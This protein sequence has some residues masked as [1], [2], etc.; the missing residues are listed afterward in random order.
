MSGV[1]KYGQDIQDRDL[2][3]E[4][5]QEHALNFTKGCYIG[6]EIVERIRSRGAVHRVFSGFI[7]TSGE[8]APG[9]K[10]SA[11]GKDN[12]GII[13]SVQ[14]V[15]TTRDGARTL[16]L[17]YIRREVVERGSKITFQGGSVEP[18]ALPFTTA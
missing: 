18:H 5:G 8:A 3:Q 2:P 12:V 10:L 16:C 17:G 4:T 9:A 1:P 13:T 6:Q 14:R 7:V 11:E 15:P